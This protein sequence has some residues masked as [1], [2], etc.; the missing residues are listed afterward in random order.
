M[1]WIQPRAGALQ[2]V[3]DLLRS[4]FSLEGQVYIIRGEWPLIFVFPASYPAPALSH[5]HS[6][7]IM[8]LMI[9]EFCFTGSV[10]GGPWSEISMKDTSVSWQISMSDYCILF[11]FFGGGNKGT[12][13]QY[14][15]AL[16]YFLHI[17][18]QVNELMAEIIY[19]WLQSY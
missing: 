2:V 14:S 19:E 7:G 17:V 9:V 15:K 13:L 12:K 10:P 18:E 6:N 11:Y 1:L 5:R 8:P 16:H 4:L 3:P